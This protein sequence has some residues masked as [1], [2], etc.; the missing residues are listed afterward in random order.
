MEWATW[1]LHPRFSFCPATRTASSV[2]S[3]LRVWTVVPSTT[4][5]AASCGMKSSAPANHSALNLFTRQCMW[6]CA[7][8]GAVGQWKR[9]PVL[10]TSKSPVG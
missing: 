9:R 4:R 1:T 8:T 3:W 5:C 10:A 6:N 2:H 7:R